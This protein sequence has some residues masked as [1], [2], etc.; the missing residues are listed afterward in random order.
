MTDKELANALKQA[1]F[2]YYGQGF[3]TDMA[4][5][6]HLAKAAKENLRPVG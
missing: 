4:Y 1:A 3:K 2:D 6:L 5:W